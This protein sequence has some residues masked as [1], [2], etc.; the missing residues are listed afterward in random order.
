MRDSAAQRGIG[1]G[2]WRKVL[3][4]SVLVSAIGCDPS[5]G[6]GA[7]GANGG[8]P[9]S[10]SPSAPGSTTPGSATGSGAGRIAYSTADASIVIDLATGKSEKVTASDALWP[11]HDGSLWASYSSTRRY[12][13]DEDDVVF[14][15]S[16]WT[17]QRTIPINKSL[18]GMVQVSPDKQR[19]AVFWADE[20]NGESYTDSILS[21]FDA[22][23][24]LLFRLPRATAFDWMPDGRL[25]YG[26]P[27]GLF[28][29]D[30]QGKNGKRIATL[31]WA[32][33]DVAVSRDGGRIALTLGATV[34]ESHIWTLA[35]DGTG[36]TQLTRSGRNE[37]SPV[38]L[39]DG[40]LLF[41]HFVSVDLEG[42]N[43]CPE[44]YV[45]PATA[46]TPI[47]PWETL[48]RDK[49]LAYTEPTSTFPRFAC[50]F[51]R[52]SWIP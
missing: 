14:Y 49:R 31:E 3:L 46:A 17:R 30:E 2:E 22:E 9:G 51:S 44:I 45:V 15:D 13:D 12:R 33:G 26:E 41:R 10:G 24:N 43:T 42:H 23:M 4:A 28:I 16:N 29:G 18:H 47:D 27:G 7:A 6:S 5:A 48:G 11:S 1:R 36:L 39:G 40:R 35:A 50:P 21:V 8:T 37:V 19:L 32:P 20:V 52:V 25:V 34:S 38:W